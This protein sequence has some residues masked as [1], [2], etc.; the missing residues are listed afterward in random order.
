MVISTL[1]ALMANRDK[2]LI[3][4]IGDAARLPSMPAVPTISETIPD[5][6]VSGWSGY[7]G[8]ANLPP[9]IAARL[10]SALAAALRKPQVIEAIRKQSMEP[11]GSSA[12]ELRSLVRS[13]LE[14][15]AP[16]I[17]RAQIAKED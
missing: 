15:W 13:G 4:A 10:S 5:F 2:L 7:F 6:V 16:V 11:A 8:P 12:E 14:R 1:P 3:I 17:E 9:A